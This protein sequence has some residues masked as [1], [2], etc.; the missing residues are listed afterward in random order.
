MNQAVKEPGATLLS[1]GFGPF[2]ALTR[3]SDQHR[4]YHTRLCCALR[5]SQPLSALFLSWPSRPYF[6]P[7]ALMGFWTLQ[8]FPLLKIGSPSG[9]PSRLDVAAG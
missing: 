7:V 2:S 9:F 5:F 3:K 4:A 6:I 8:S 1:W